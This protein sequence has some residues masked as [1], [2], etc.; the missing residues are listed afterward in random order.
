LH[1]PDF[2]AF[3]QHV[4]GGF[5]FVRILCGIDLRDE[6]LLGRYWARDWQVVRR[7]KIHIHRI[8]EEAL[9]KALR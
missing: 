2:V 9:V 8:I 7:D 5:V 4:G 3:E 1:V 6:V